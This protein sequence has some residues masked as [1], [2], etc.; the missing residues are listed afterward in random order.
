MGWGGL[1]PGRLMAGMAYGR[2]GVGQ[3]VTSRAGAVEPRTTS[4]GS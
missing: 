3:A 2:G 4:S 1:G